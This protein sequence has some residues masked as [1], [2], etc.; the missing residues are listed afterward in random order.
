MCDP[1]SARYLA[2]V[3]PRGVKDW[4]IVGELEHLEWFVERCRLLAQF[5]AYA[6][7]VFRA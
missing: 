5:L 6:L 3:F 7:H 1:P 4:G 2:K